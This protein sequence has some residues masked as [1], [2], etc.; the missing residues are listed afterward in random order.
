MMVVE[1]V[2]RVEELLGHARKGD[3][4]ALDDAKAQLQRLRKALTMTAAL[5][6]AGVASYE[7]PIRLRKSWQD[8]VNLYKW[9]EAQ[10][11]AGSTVAEIHAYL[12]QNR[13]RFEAEL[14]RCRLAS[15]QNFPKYLR[16]ALRRLQSRHRQRKAARKG[17]SAPKSAPPL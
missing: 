3:P 10:V 8:A 5:A 13:S 15:A 12:R 11:P 7:G 14:P 2:D 1:M 9:A 17:I 4:F 16:Q 6:D